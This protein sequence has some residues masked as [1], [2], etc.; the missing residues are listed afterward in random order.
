MSI[1]TLKFK[2]NDLKFLYKY[3]EY[4]IC[5]YFEELRYQIDS[6]YSSFQLSSLVL[7]DNWKKLIKSVYLQEATIKKEFLEKKHSLQLNPFYNDI[8]NVNSDLIE[9]LIYEKEVELF[10]NKSFIF[11][12]IKNNNININTQPILRYITSRNNMDHFSGQLI[13]FE[14]YYLDK[15]S[16]K[17]IKRYKFTI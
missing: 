11:I 5:N 14:D 13:I 16:E 6:Y 15:Q 12:N 3:Q 9:K 2:H 17:I 7:I 1:T 4:Y 10:N 8:N